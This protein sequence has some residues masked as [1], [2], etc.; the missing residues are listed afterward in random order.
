[1]YSNLLWSFYFP[2]SCSFV[3][4]AKYSTQNTPFDRKKEKPS[5]LIGHK[6]LNNRRESKGKAICN[7]CSERRNGIFQ[8]DSHSQQGD[9]KNSA[10]FV[11]ACTKDLE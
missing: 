10:K 3:L 2:R 7:I 5:H 9:E 8:D 11:G 6:S 4:A 1:M